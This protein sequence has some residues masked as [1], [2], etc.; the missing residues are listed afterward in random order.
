MK[1]RAFH[2]SFIVPRSSFIAYQFHDDLALAGAVELAEEDALPAAQEESAV[3]EWD[4]RARA[5]ERSLDV[6]VRVLLAVAKIH[7]MLRNQCA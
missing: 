6:R 5:D 3:M 1:D 4:G 7:P 2:S